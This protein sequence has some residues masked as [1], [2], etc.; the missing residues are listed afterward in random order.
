MALLE[1]NFG[2]GLSF[3]L[4]GEL[5]YRRPYRS[6]W[7]SLFSVWLR[8]EETKVGQVSIRG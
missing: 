5:S 2:N 6:Y 3:D 7:L 4:E 1:S 8:F